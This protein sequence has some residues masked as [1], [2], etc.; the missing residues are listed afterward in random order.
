MQSLCTLRTPRCR[1][2]RNTRY[3]AARYALPGRD[4]HPLDRASFAWR[5]VS[6]PLIT[7]IATRQSP[8]SGADLGRADRG[9]WQQLRHRLDQP[10]QT[11]T[12]R[13][14]FRRNPDA[15]LAELEEKDGPVPE[16]VAVALSLFCPL[17]RRE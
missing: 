2:A 10:R 16:L 5:T 1:D 6:G 15:Y 7:A 11:R 13:T 3:R 14:R 8:P 9:Q 12:L 17:C 4:L